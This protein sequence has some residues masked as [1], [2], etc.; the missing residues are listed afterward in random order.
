MLNYP[1]PPAPDLCLRL[2]ELSFAI[3]NQI[4]AILNE[5]EDWKKVKATFDQLL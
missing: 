1:L 3:H 5:R 2:T 4:C